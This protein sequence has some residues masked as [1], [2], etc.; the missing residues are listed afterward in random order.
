MSEWGLCIAGRAERYLTAPCR[1]GVNNAKVHWMLLSKTSEVRHGI[2]F[3]I[4]LTVQICNARSYQS[5][6]DHMANLNPSFSKALN[7]T[8]YPYMS[9]RLVSHQGKC[10]AITFSSCLRF[11]FSL[12]G[13]ACTNDRWCV[14]DEMTYPTDLLLHCSLQQPSA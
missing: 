9:A 5:C 1:F 2:V 4:L 13:L 14:W 8:T 6:R 3:T 11:R 10:L 7:T 12:G